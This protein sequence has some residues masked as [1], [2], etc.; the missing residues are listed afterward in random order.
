MPT[1]VEWLNAAHAGVRSRFLFGPSNEAVRGYAWTKEFVHGN[2]PN[3]VKQLL[4]NALGL[5]DVLGN[6]WEL[7]SDRLDVSC[8]RYLS[9]NN[10]RGL[11]MSNCMGTS[12]VDSVNNCH[13][14]YI[15]GNT[16][17]PVVSFG[18]R[19]LEDIENHSSNT[20]AVVLI[21][22]N[23]P[24]GSQALTSQPTPITGL[25]TW[26][27]ALAGKHSDSWRES[28]G[29]RPIDGL[30]NTGKP[31]R[32]LGFPRLQ[33]RFPWK[34]DGPRR[35]YNRTNFAR[36]KWIAITND[37]L[38][39]NSNIHLWNTQTR[40]MEVILQTKQQGQL[41]FSPDSSR[42]I[43]HPPQPDYFSGRGLLEFDLASRAIRLL[44]TDHPVSA[45]AIAPHSD[46]FYTLS[47]AND[48]THL[49]CYVYPEMNLLSSTKIEEAKW[50]NWVSVSPNG[51]LLQLGVD[52]RELRVL[53]AESK[54]LIQ[55]IAWPVSYETAQAT[56]YSDCERL[57]IANSAELKVVRIQGEKPLFQIALGCNKSPILD[58]TRN[59]II[60]YPYA[61]DSFR[62][63][64]ATTGA[65]LES[66]PVFKTNSYF[67][68]ATNDSDSTCLMAKRLLALMES[69]AI[70]SRKSSR[71][72]IILGIGPS[73]ETDKL[74]FSKDL[75]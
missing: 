21:E 51:K 28:I 59:R 39:A 33:W 20:S 2:M 55:S 27:L 24:F 12:Y 3:A 10:P 15:T 7:T 34:A 50:A 19:V 69:R 70:E 71:H 26:S 23:I 57:L 67:L 74:L 41:A 64:D 56:W 36:R 72:S 6:L 65:E 29:N 46:K 43:L 38:R 58:E 35:L 40:K 44:R 52:N 22:K 32:C 66:G 1:E 45:F 9:T 17:L 30:V 5:H 60:T 4:P 75:L 61:A 11:A 54:S 8:G 73:A 42:L 68:Q 49:H 53:D 14:R 63:F 25:R 48:E 47:H 13:T 18:F 37:N 16:E 62:L 31:F